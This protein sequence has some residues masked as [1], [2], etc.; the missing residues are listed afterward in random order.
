RHGTLV[1]CPGT[2]LERVFGRGAL[3]RPEP[4]EQNPGFA[5]NAH[6]TSAAR[7][8]HVRRLAGLADS[9]ETAGGGAPGGADRAAPDC[10]TAQPAGLVPQ[11]LPGGTH[12][13]RG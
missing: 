3:L 11:A 10:G 6:E 7:A 1:G 13:G 4:S 8:G 9:E 2:A 12:A 5:G